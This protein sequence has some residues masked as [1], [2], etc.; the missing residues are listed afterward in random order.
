MIPEEELINSK[1]FKELSRSDQNEVMEHHRRTIGDVA[2]DIGVTALKGAVGLGESAVGLANLATPGVDIG[3]FAK[4]KLGYDPARTKE[5]LDT[6]YSPAQKEAFRNVEEAKGFGA[7]SREL[8]KNPST[9][10]HAVLETAPYLLG[11]IGVGGVTAKIAPKLGSLGKVPGIVSEALKGSVV[12]A[13]KSAED[14]RQETGTLTPS[15]SAQAVGQGVQRGVQNLVTGKIGAGLKVPL[16]GRVTLGSSVRQGKKGAVEKKR[17]P[18][19]DED[20]TLA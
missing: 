2:G 4:E 12:A 14:I 7:T 3:S 10:G 8:I 1:E 11:G 20:V 17:T 9:I 18:L 6:L 5:H 13:G 16:A 15:Q 19:L